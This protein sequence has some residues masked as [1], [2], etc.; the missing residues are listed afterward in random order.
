MTRLTVRSFVAGGPEWRAGSAWWWPWAAVAAAGI[1]LS[2][3]AIG[4]AA[5]LV[6]G[7]EEAQGP[8]LSH[9]LMQLLLVT[10]ITIVL[11]VLVAARLRGT[12]TGDLRLNAPATGPASYRLAI[13]VLV[14]VVV[15]INSAMFAINPAD[16]LAD[17]RQF[18]DLSR[19]SSPLVPGL[20]ICLGAPLS[21]ELL[22]RGLLLQPLASS[23]L[24]F[25]SAAVV[26]VAAW[27]VL[28]WNYSW[29]GLLEVF[30]IGLFLSWTLWRT[31]SLR[32]PIFCH[33]AYNTVLFL[34][35]R[36]WPA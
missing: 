11:M 33:A 18:L 25:W 34:A 28:H 29:A 36:Y 13:A 17:L 26:V 16:P 8:D 20:V 6:L 35:M 3:Q 1:F 10:Q 12:M 15:V 2:S 4:V 5:A 32:V 14:P 19:S 22:F 24:G 30:V 23:R 21:E 9:K 31:G 27:T 7:A